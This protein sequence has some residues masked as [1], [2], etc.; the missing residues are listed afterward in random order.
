MPLTPL[1]VQPSSAGPNACPDQPTPAGPPGRQPD[2]SSNRY[3][4]QP[5]DTLAGIGGAHGESRQELYRQKKVVLERNP[6]LIHPGQTL[7]FR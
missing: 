4:V 1:P 5:G 6:H 7:T 2:P 3:I